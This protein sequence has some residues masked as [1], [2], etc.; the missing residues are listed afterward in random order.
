MSVPG[1]VSTALRSAQHDISDHTC[2]GVRT[3]RPNRSDADERSTRCSRTARNEMTHFV[4]LSHFRRGV[5]CPGIPRR[6][7]IPDT[8]LVN[9]ALYFAQRNKYLD[10]EGHCNANCYLQATS[11]EYEHVKQA[12]PVIMSNV[13]GSHGKG[14]CGKY[15]NTQPMLTSFPFPGMFRLRFAPL[16][17]T[18]GKQRMSIVSHQKTSMQTTLQFH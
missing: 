15:S 9:A 11:I 3:H 6:D 12:S 1:D 16:N 2:N 10:F 17:M 5:A 14:P 7:G 18:Y 13:E 8:R 4:I